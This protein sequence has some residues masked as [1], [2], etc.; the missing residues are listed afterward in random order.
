MNE[1]QKWNEAFKAV[2]NYKP[3]MNEILLD[4]ILARVTNKKQAIDL[5]C[6]SGD[7][8]VKLAKRGLN[9]TGYDWSQAALQ[10]AQ[11]LAGQ[12]GVTAKVQLQEVDLE[13]LADANL[14]RGTADI[15]LC[16]HTIAFITDKQA[17]CEAV[18]TLLNDTGVFVIQTPVLRKEITYTLEDKPE[19][20][21]SYAECTSIL[22]EVFTNVTE[23]NHSYYGDRSE[24]LTFVVK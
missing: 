14:P 13:H 19:I 18:A 9:V 16:K 20:A 3:L 10:N 8:V 7:A 24:L 22:T 1:Q 6:G 15:V 2:R 11:T 5:G 12:A 4:R 23:F 21:V 17:F